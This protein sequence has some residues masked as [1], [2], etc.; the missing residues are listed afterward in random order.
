[1]DPNRRIAQPGPALEPR[2]IAVPARATLREFSLAPG[3][4]L[5]DALHHALGDCSGAVLHLQG[6][7]F[8]PFHYVMPA[9]CATSE[10]A[11]F[12][13]PV[14]TPEGATTIEA[15]RITYGLRDGAPWLHCHGFWVE[16]DGRRNGGHVIPDLTRVAEAINVC[17]WT[18]D[19]AAFVARHDPETNFTLLAPEPT[20][21]PA[22]SPNAYA[23]RLRPNQDICGALEDFCTAHGIASATIG[24]GVASI[25]GAVFD[26]GRVCTP[27]AT[28]IF[29]QHGTIARNASGQMEAALDIGLVN[30][31]GDLTQGRLQRGANPV[32]MTVELVLLTR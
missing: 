2:V 17:A 14:F 24:G 20:A 16:P 8:G 27:F 3:D 12:Y 9:L 5:L 25:I 32:L 26:D 13:S 23:I 18:L 21:T 19:G 1:M 29:I 10:H 11:A 4:I 7:A 30:Y 31:Q 28:E 15:A 6:G 22:G